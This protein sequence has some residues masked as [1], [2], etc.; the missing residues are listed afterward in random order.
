MSRPIRAVLLLLLAAV[1]LAGSQSPPNNSMA[2]ET[3]T[4]GYWV[5]TSG[6]MWAAKDNG[7]DV[8]WKGA[9]KYCRDL[10]LAGYSDWRLASVDELQGIYDGSGFMA[11]HPRNVI[12]VLAGRA[13]GGLLLTGSRE[14]SSNR[15]LDD[16]GRNTGYAWEYD[17][18]HGG[19][20]K[21]PLGYNATLRALCV[22][23]SEK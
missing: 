2:E 20:W 21:D 22:R 8:S 1:K 9:L 5:D 16:R 13:K 11:P 18:P 6:L 4:R 19:P 14:W 3:Q 10:R 15:V 17:Y 7:K 23:G 12:L